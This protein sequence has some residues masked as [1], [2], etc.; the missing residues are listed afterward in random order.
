MFFSSLSL[1]CYQI[2]RS[3]SIILLQYLVMV[4]LISYYTDQELNKGERCNAGNIFASS[5]FYFPL[6]N[7][8][9]LYSYSLTSPRAF[10]IFFSIYLI[11]VILKL[12]Y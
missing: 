5:N 3:Q 1:K 8:A 2:I 4:F 7:L 6:Q 11:L 10:I 9:R 12:N